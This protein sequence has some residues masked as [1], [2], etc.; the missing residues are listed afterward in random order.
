MKFYWNTATLIHVHVVHSC[1][2]TIRRSWV[3]V[4]ETHKAQNIYT[5]ALYRNRFLS[6]ILGYKLIKDVGTPSTHSTTAG[7]SYLLSSHT[8]FSFSSAF[9]PLLVHLAYPDPLLLSLPCPRP[10]PSCQAGP[11]RDQVGDRR[12][13]P[14]WLVPHKVSAGMD[15]PETQRGTAA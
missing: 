13:H 14:A 12:E 5:L 15:V 4:I 7:L 10:A 2:C 9:S 11:I 6:P 8:C 3:V 1:I